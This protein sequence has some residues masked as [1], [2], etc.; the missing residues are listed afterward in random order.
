MGT[1]T[2]SEHT[3]SI[4]RDFKKIILRVIKKEILK[5]H[6]ILNFIWVI[7]ISCWLSLLQ[8]SLPVM[9]IKPRLFYRV[10]KNLG[11]PRPLKGWYGTQWTVCGPYSKVLWPETREY[12]SGAALHLKLS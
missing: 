11:R 7:D 8:L 4:F 10:V 3:M 12:G 9:E 2:L 6:W 1:A 5:L